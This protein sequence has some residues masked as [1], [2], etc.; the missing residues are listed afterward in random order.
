MAPQ[1]LTPALA[2]PAPSL[3]LIL[4]HGAVDCWHPSL[5]GKRLVRGVGGCRRGVEL[6]TAISELR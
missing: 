4:A 1:G 6:P 2:L 5:P 3:A